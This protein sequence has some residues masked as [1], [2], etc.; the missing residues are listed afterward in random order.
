MAEK[1]GFEPAVPVHLCFAKNVGR[2]AGF[3]S[4]RHTIERAEIGSN[5]AANSGTQSVPAEIVGWFD[6]VIVQCHWTIDFGA[7]FL[8]AHERQR[9][10]NANASAAAWWN[11]IAWAF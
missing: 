4:Y 1:G 2:N 3:S 5:F 8:S 6:G 7:G 11:F 10:A 9:D